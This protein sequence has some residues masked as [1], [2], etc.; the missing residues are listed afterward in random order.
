[1]IC[2]RKTDWLGNIKLAQTKKNYPTTEEANNILSEPE[3]LYE[4]KSIQ[5]FSSFEEMENDQLKYMA[6]L[7]P[8]ERSNIFIIFSNGI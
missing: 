1:M 6:S 3:A 5:R 2:L 8:K 7:S 4:K